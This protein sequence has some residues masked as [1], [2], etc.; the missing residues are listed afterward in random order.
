[1]DL[2]PQIQNLKEF[3]LRSVCVGTNRSLDDC[4]VLQDLVIQYGPSRTLLLLLVVRD[5]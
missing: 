2:T 1:V 5:I 4:D 3:I